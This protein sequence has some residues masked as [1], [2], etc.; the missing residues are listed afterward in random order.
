M[1]RLYCCTYPGFWVV[2]GARV[3]APLVAAKFEILPLLPGGGKIPAVPKGP[4]LAQVKLE[5]VWPAR[6]QLLASRV[7]LGDKPWFVVAKKGVVARLIKSLSGFNW[8]ET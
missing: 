3:G 1:S 4:A 6:V 2:Y 5:I 7:A 8:K